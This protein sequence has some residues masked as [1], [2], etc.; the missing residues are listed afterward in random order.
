MQFW[1]S[2]AISKNRCQ[3]LQ[4]CNAKNYKLDWSNL[5]LEN[6]MESI[7]GMRKLSDPSDVLPQV[8]SRAL[9]ATLTLYK[10]LKN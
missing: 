5:K 9:C 7:R 10:K 3:K 8:M 4:T 6:G 1:Q 2:E